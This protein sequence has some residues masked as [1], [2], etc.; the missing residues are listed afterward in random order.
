MKIMH[1]K[2]NTIEDTESM[3]KTLIITF[4]DILHD[5]EPHLEKILS[6]IR[7]DITY[8]DPGLFPK[9]LLNDEE[10]HRCRC[11]NYW[12]MYQILRIAS[13]ETYESISESY[14]SLQK[15]IIKASY[16]KQRWL[17]LDTLREFI[18]LLNQMNDFKKGCPEA[19][20]TFY[21]AFQNV[22]AQENSIG[23]F[24]L[25]PHQPRVC[26]ARISQFTFQ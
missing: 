25:L 10:R 21:D 16:I 18:K 13:L 6:M 8:D 17:A 23:S 15:E 22:T 19:I 11:S 7:T 24:N 9:T 26:N 14:T 5:H 20:T 12:L 4:A 2:L 1:E 3:W